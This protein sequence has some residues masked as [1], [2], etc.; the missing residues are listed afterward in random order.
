M[1]AFSTRL[2]GVSS[3]PY[4][5]LNLGRDVGDRVEDVDAN[6]RLFE[7]AC[8]FPRPVVA[9]SQVHGNVVRVVE[10]GDDLTAKPPGDA[11]VT[12]LKGVPIG[13][14]TA[15]CLPVLFYGGDSGVIGAAHCG[16]RGVVAGAAV[17]C[18][19][20]MKKMGAAPGETIAALGPAI[21][22]RNFEVGREVVERFEQANLLRPGV[23]AG[24]KDGKYFISLQRAVRFQLLDCGLSEANI[25]DL[26]YCTFDNEKL[27]YSHRRDK[28][29][30]GRHIS[31][32]CLV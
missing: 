11:L 15:D 1:H 27:F 24:E 14:R 21:S 17:K 16:W 12:A 5:Y 22:E 32:I 9:N 26:D 2:G 4:A 30:T 7:K 23:L 10:E 19:E 13:I 28:G 8:S 3:G 6:Y 29:V 31:A 20:E 18:V 25:D